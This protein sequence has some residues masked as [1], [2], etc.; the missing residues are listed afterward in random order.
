M[1]AQYQ[2]DVSLPYL[3]LFKGS[4]KIIERLKFE[5][6]LLITG[7]CAHQRQLVVKIFPVFIDGLNIK[8]KYL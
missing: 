2:E 1:K 8:K 3:S 5:E 7:L 6:L 4:N